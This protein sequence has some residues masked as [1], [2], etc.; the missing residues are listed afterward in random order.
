VADADGAVTEEEERMLERQ[1]ESSLHLSAAE[2]VRLR[3]HLAWLLAAAPGTSGLKK[4]LSALDEAQRRAVGRYLVAVAGADGHFDPSE[5]TALTKMYRL[6]AFTAADAYSDIHALASATPAADKPVTVQ[7]ADR[8]PTGFAI[9]APPTPEAPEPGTVNLDMQRVQQTIE[10]TRAVATLLTD[11]LEDEEPAPPEAPPTPVDA[12]D[13]LDGSH[14]AL[15]R[16]LAAK[17]SWSRADLEM[18]AATHGLL[19]DGAIDAINE[20]ALDRTGEM[21]CNGDDPVT[22]DLTIASELLS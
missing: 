1:L 13:G 18:L 15:A 9:P 3:A 8:R 10:E 5:V 7:E 4:R 6:L 21:L 20:A 16:Q 22:V 19:P 12:V 14:S 2:R 17:E 11:I